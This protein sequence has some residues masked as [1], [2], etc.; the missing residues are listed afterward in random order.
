MESL[1]LFE[2][3]KQVVTSWQVIV[4]VVVIAI[5]INLVS[6]VARKHRGP[7]KIKLSIRSKKPKQEKAAEPVVESSST[8]SAN[9]ELGLEEE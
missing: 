7:S 5:Y 2:I 4:A 3:L 9:D 8:K 6:F 1:S